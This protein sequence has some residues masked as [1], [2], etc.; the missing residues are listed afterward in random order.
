MVKQL[1]NKLQKSFSPSISKRNLAVD[2]RILCLFT[3]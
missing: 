3:S 2:G 1:Y